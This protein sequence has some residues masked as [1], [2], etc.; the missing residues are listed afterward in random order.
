MP[1][2]SDM[3]DFDFEDLNDFDNVSKV[4]LKRR[5]INA[6]IQGVSYNCNNMVILMRIKTT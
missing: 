4:I 5:L 6:L 1:E 3:R 2:S